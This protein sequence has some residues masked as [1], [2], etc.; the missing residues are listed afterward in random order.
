MKFFKFLKFTLLIQLTLRILS[1]GSDLGIVGRVAPHLKITKW[2]DESGKPT[3]DFSKFLDWND[4]VVLI[5]CWQSWCPGCHSHG[6]PTFKELS[7][8]FKNDE[9]IIILSIQTVFEGHHTNT[10]DK[11]SK[12]MSDYG[13]QR[14]TGHD[15]GSRDKPGVA[16]T[17]LSYRTGGTPWFIIIDKHRRV[18]FNGS[19]LDVDKAIKAIEKLASKS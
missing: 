9:R 16:E 4:K 15:S 1:Y 2:F 5:F 12:V 13:I 6:L 14:P 18:V 17:I 8:H 19:R 10:S 11:I 3:K 7:D